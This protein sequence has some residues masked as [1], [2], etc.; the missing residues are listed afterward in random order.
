MRVRPFLSSLLVS[1]SVPAMTIAAI[2]NPPLPMTDWHVSPMMASNASDPNYCAMAT[3]YTNGPTVTFTRN[4]FDKGSIAVDFPHAQLERGKQYGV[5]LTLNGQPTSYAGKAIS[6]TQLVLQVGVNK[7]LDNALASGQ[8]LTISLDGTEGVFNLAGN[9]RAFF[10]FDHCL[11]ALRQDNMNNVASVSMPAPLVPTADVQQED[12]P[13]K[14]TPQPRNTIASVSPTQ[15]QPRS[16]TVSNYVQQ[17]KLPSKPVLPLPMDLRPHDDG[18]ADAYGVLPPTAKVIRNTV[19]QQDLS[20]A[21]AWD[22]PQ[23]GPA[24]PQIVQPTP[25]ATKADQ[26]KSSLAQARA[27]AKGAN[28]SIDAAQTATAAKTQTVAAPPVVQSSPLPQV[29]DSEISNL[30]FDNGNAPSARPIA[31][32]PQPVPAALPAPIV[33]NAPVKNENIAP[34]RKATVKAKPVTAAKPAQPAAP[35]FD[36]MSIATPVPVAAAPK[37]KANVATVAEAAAPKVEESPAQPVVKETAPQPAPVAP[38]IKPAPIK[39]AEAA[40]QPAPQPAPATVT[41]VAPPAKVETIASTPAPVVSRNVT[42]LV[43]APVAPI[44]PAPVIP[45]PQPMP[46]PEAR[47]VIPDLPPALPPAIKP[48]MAVSAEP[49]INPQ[50]AATRMAVTRAR[51]LNTVTPSVGA[52]PVKPVFQQVTA[53]PRGNWLTENV[54]ASAPGKADGYCLMQN[55]FDNDTSVMIGERAD[56]FSTLGVNYGIDMLQKSKTYNVTVQLDNIF[57]EDFSGYAESARTLVV[58]LG[59]K[60]SFLASLAT[61]Q[62]MRIAIPGVS[63]GY[64]LQGVA[65][66]LNGFTDCLTALGGTPPQLNTANAVPNVPNERVSS[67]DLNAPPAAQMSGRIGQ[68]AW[69]DTI[70]P[71]LVDAG[72]INPQ[73]SSDKNTATWSDGN[74]QGRVENAG[75]ADIMDA[76]SGAIDRAEKSCANGFNAQMGLPDMAG[77]QVLQ[78]M[79]SKCAANNGVTAWVAQQKGAQTNV[80]SVQAP[81]EKKTLAFQLRDKLVRL[82]QDK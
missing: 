7:T 10:E 75:D 55:Q 20:A 36:E 29:R 16:A 54:P 74:V 34:V 40:V 50:P 4:A 69:S 45:A 59:K 62:A 48:T 46:M 66:A 15:P 58:Q 3:R 49:V 17:K 47:E 64:K 79:E 35:A 77:S 72:I 25:V 28:D 60:A 63:S 61:A 67:S 71:I 65:A 13:A 2:Q 42:P 39:Q 23:V 81:R 32:H 27:Q 52:T 24:A 8:N 31:M 21:V 12:L 9:M 26:L 38:A 53:T 11:K 43:A 82:L 80:W 30:L 19:R 22:A 56:G 76:A 57:E 78:S 14:L 41:A 51:D 5:T 44:V 68:M 73:F 37:A 6:E 18:I 70:R 33:P 1:V